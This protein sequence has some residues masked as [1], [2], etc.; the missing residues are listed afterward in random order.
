MTNSQLIFMVSGI[1]FHGA[2]S[3]QHV[4]VHQG[5]INNSLFTEHMVTA[6]KHAIYNMLLSFYYCLKLQSNVSLGIYV[7]LEKLFALWYLL[8]MW[9]VARMY[10][11]YSNYMCCRICEFA[12]LNS[13]HFWKYPE[14]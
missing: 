1:I 3:G 4:I 6:L 14:V 10:T 5:P 8:A 7:V 11:R 12:F 2:V 9:Y 13:C